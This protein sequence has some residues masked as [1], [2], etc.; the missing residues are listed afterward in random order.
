MQRARTLPLIVLMLLFLHGCNTDGDS[1]NP[2]RTEPPAQTQNPVQ[3]QNNSDEV[4]FESDFISVKTQG[5]GPDVILI[6]GFA[7]SSDVWLGVAK[8]IGPRFRLHLISVAGLAS[9]AAAENVPESYLETIRDEIARYIEATKLKQPILIGHSMGGLLSLLVSS[10]EP[11]MVG[12]VIIVDALPFFSLL[13]N[14]LATAEQVLPQAKAMEKQMLSLDDMQFEQQAKSSASILTKDDKKKKLL[15]QWSKESD[16]KAYAQ[17]FREIMAYDA[18]P[19]LNK[20]TCPVL[21]VYAYDK[22]M[23]V[24]EAQLAQLYANAYANVKGVRIQRVADS[25]HFIMW[26]QPERFQKT[27]NEVL[28]R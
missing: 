2:A 28:S 13:F 8:E 4:P 6:H 9:S 27:L 19:E 11:S 20:I 3:S 22:A 14:P 10:T 25:F 26:D 17:I 21:V 16:R 15:L 7:S 1:S 24:P 5:T 12:Q 18:R 23:F